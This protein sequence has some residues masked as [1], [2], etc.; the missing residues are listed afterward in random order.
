LIRALVVALLASGS[1]GPSFDSRVD[2]ERAVERARYRFAI[3]ATQPFDEAYPR[4]VFE[5]KV[6]REMAEERV[7]EKTF[8]FTV[9]PAVL[10]AE[11]DRI[12]KTTKA[13]D[14]WEAIKLALK[15]DRRRIEEVFCR[16]LVVER[17][18]RAKF[19]FDLKIHAEPRQRA[20]EARKEFLAGNAPPGV[21]TLSLSRAATTVPATKELLDQAKAETSVPRVLGVPE[22]TSRDAPVPIDPEMAAVL[23]RQL[24]KPGDVT[25]ILEERDRVSVFRL[26]EKT[27]KTWKVDAVTFPKV[28]FDAWFEK[29]RRSL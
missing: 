19:A 25:T 4:S 13:P 1:V 27:E 18:L 22:K 26:K 14:Q 15:N 7:L 23:E 12:E 28:E 21:S 10:A 16:P 9:T 6:G 8:G 11:F 2:G 17:A 3:G 5:K 24:Q 20:R 29:A